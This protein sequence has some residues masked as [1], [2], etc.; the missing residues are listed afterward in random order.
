MTTTN[1]A[2]LTFYSGAGEAISLSIP[3]ARMDKT[4][5]AARTTMEGML[6]NGALLIGGRRPSTVRSAELIQ[7]QRNVIFQG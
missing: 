3:R 4:P 6:D 2:Q 5:D 7:T 1:R